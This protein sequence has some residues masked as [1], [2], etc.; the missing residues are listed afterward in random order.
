MSSKSNTISLGNIQGLAF[1]AV[2]KTVAVN[3]QQ[4]Y[5]IVSNIS[6]VIYSSQ[7]MALMGLSG[8]GKTT[9]L[10]ILSGQI[11]RQDYDGDILLDGNKSWVLFD[12]VNMYICT[13]YIIT[14]AITRSNCE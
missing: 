3:K 14:Q 4:D 6:G 8:C 9:L 1:N 2:T 13:W 12:K 7:M 11:P 10:H 5:H